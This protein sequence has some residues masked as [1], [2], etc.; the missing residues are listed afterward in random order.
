MT[1][2]KYLWRACYVPNI[3]AGTEHTKQFW[4]CPHGILLPVAN[5]PCVDRSKIT[6][7]SA[8]KERRRH[9]GQ[10][11]QT[12]TPSASLVFSFIAVSG[13]S[14][15]SVGLL[16]PEGY[17][18][19]GMQKRRVRDLRVN[20]RE[21]NQIRDTQQGSLRPMGLLSFVYN[22][23]M[24]EFPRDCRNTPQEFSSQGG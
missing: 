5:K 11:S 13:P 14:Q 16:C 21:A 8:K 20:N 15:S 9:G 2:Y 10:R 6:P 17:H 24:M 7:P 18:I 23:W 22:V 1:F 3:V 4:P 19:S 12:K